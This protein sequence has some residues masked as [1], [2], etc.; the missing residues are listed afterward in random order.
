MQLQFRH[1]AA[2]GYGLA[3]ASW[4]VT[5]LA[6]DE[7][8]PV[9]IGAATVGVGTLAAAVNRWWAMVP[10][11]LVSVFFAVNLAFLREQLGAPDS[12]LDFVPA[13]LTVA[14][15]IIG[16]ALCVVEFVGRARHIR[17]VVPMLQVRALGLGAGAIGVLAAF[18]VVLTLTADRATVS[19]DEREG[20]TTVV[21]RNSKFVPRTIT[22]TAG[23]PLRIVVD[24]RDLIIHDIDMPSEGVKSDLGPKEEKLV[25]VTFDNPGEYEVR[26]TLHPNMTGKIIVE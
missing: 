7:M 26:C 8:P 6:I 14:A 18:S 5:G 19:A 23:Q 11:L 10:P 24:N 9:I 16:A 17:T 1:I 20:A 12:A 2:I 13:I 21:F 25:E 3:G 15:G 22:A 4:V